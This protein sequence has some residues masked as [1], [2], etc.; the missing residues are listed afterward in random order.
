MSEAFTRS[1]CT[2]LACGG[3]WFR[4]ASYFA[5]L[6]EESLGPF[7]DTWPDLTGQASY[8]PMTVRVCLCGAP[9][10]PEIGGL[11]GG[12][13]PNRE[14]C[15]FLESLAKAKKQLKENHDPG[16]VLGAAEQQLVKLDAFHATEK[17]LQQC[18]STWASGCAE[19]PG[20]FGNR[21]R[22]RPRKRAGCSTAMA[23]V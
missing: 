8:I 10:D 5:F 11:R 16:L 9:L 13:T 4:E 1:T 23:W 21:L 15:R 3:E 18:K 17:Q 22:A 14:L 19:G 2:C 7:W 20:G 6:P 12:R